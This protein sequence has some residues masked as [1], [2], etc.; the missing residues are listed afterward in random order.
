[1]ARPRGFAAAAAFVSMLAC[2]RAQAPSLPA[3]DGTRALEHARQLAAIGPRVAGS[4]GAQHA[5]DYIK[6]QLSALGLIAQE[7]P[8]EAS[9]PLGRV[10]MVNLRATVSGAAASG[11]L[12]VAGHYDTKLFRD[13]RFVGANDGG[14][15][16]AFLIELAGVLKAR[17]NPLTIEILFLDGEE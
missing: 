7:Q 12:I 14:S 17:R 3:F 10:K 2:A 8:F 15:S 13:F 11:R 9:T 16:A 1:M 6:Q 4:P 5:R